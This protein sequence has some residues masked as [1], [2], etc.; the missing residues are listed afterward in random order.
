[1]NTHPPSGRR[2]RVLLWSVV[3]LGLCFL[4]AAHVVYSAVSLTRDAAALRGS[5][6]TAMDGQAQT[7]VQ[8]S[9]GPVFLGLARQLLPLIDDVPEEALCALRSVRSAS[10]GVFELEQSLPAG[11]D[12]VRSADA[13]MR[14][15]G[16]TRVL[17][18]RDGASTVL[19]YAPG[20]ASRGAEMDLCLAV[21]EER[22][23]VIVAAS[24]RPSDLLPLIS[25]RGA[26]P[27]KI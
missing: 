27:E 21:V 24:V 11:G 10:V 1:M 4:G 19:V 5:V 14:N 2:R 18:V 12:Y 15:R 6:L 9:V 3:F 16:W 13:S 26:W 22:N 23:V 20:K 25:Q 8:V 17:A 7:R